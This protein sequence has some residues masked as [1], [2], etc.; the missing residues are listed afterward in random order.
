MLLDSWS[1]ALT[2]GSL[3][4]I[5]L[6]ATATR[7]GVR[8]LR[9][10]N[11]SSDGQQQIRLESE[12]WLSSTL[13]AYALGIQILSLVLLVLAADEFAGMIKGAMC[14]T[15]SLLANGFGMPAL[16][17][18]LA[19]VFF[20]GF[21]LLLHH[22]DI[23]SESYPL[24]RGKFLFLL[25]LLPL[26][27]ADVALQTLYL[28]NLTPDIITSCCA[29]VFSPE[30]GSGPNL[31]AGWS[32][33]ALLSFFYSSAV[34]LAGLGGWL[35]FNGRQGQRSMAKL[36]YSLAWLCFLGLALVVIT[37]AVSSYVYAMPFHRCPF[38]ILKPQYGY[39]GFALYGSLL[40]AAFFGITVWP[41]GWFS[42]RP[43]LSAA[44]A[45]YQRLACRT[46]LFLLFCFIGLASFHW[47]RYFFAGGE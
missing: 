13:V 29:V 43:G 21:W 47:L 3:I 40:A 46:S 14:A 32:E 25:A 7:T 11:P 36:L 22:L 5:F 35:L 16:L 24:V 38:C 42:D 30:S 45:G 23:Q 9:H 2:L 33:T 18:K 6:V 39:I 17:V 8:V 37:T 12:I 41:A 28:F 19:G 27:G 34:I 15:G 20:Y 44:V 31:L 10:W 4:V 1:L 26:L